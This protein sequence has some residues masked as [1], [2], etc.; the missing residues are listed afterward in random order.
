MAHFSNLTSRISQRANR[1]TASTAAP[2]SAEY[3]LIELVGLV[4][5]L[6]PAR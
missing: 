3:R 5:H 1:A 4:F 6:F 2:L